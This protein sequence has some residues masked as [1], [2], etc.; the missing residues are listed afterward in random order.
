MTAR[1]PLATVNTMLKTAGAAAL[2]MGGLT[3]TAKGIYADI[4]RMYNTAIPFRGLMLYKGTMPTQSELDALDGTA[5]ATLASSFR[6]ADLLIQFAP[7]SAPSYVNDTAL[8]TFV[9]AAPI[10][11]GTAT[12]FLF[13][14]FNNSGT[15]DNHVYICGSVGTTGADLNILTTTLTAG[16]L[17]RFPQFGLQLPKKLVF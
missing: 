14:A 13:G 12:W 11:A 7:T 2:A 9:P 10:Q 1:F 16:Q 4:V 8:F 17:Y 5:Y 6:Y 15:T 3:P